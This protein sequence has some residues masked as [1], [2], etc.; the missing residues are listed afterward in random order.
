MLGWASVTMLIP[1]LVALVLFPRAPRLM[2]LLGILGVLWV[3]YSFIITG[4]LVSLGQAAHWFGAVQ[5]YQPNIPEM[6]ILVLGVAVAAALIKLGE[7]FLGERQT[8]T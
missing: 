4:Q 7:Q 6:L 8:T 3:Q 2:A 1:F 5:T